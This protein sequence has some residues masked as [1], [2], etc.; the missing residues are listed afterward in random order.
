MEVSHRFKNHCLE[1]E[2]S[3]VTIDHYVTQSARFMDYL[4][5]QRISHCG[6]IQSPVGL[7][8][9]SKRWQ[10]ILTKPWNKNICSLRAFFKFLWGERR[11]PDGFFSQDA[12][13]AG[14]ETKPY[15]IGLDER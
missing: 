4:D 6:E 8:S 3:K 2:Y 13:G 11:S 10:A 7:M 12:H 15:P 1:K 9:T 5:S 14:K